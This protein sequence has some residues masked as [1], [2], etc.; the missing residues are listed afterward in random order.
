MREPQGVHLI[1]DNLGW[2]E[3][4]PVNVEELV[5]RAGGDQAGVFTVTR[6]DVEMLLR[7]VQPAAAQAVD[8]R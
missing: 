4:K 6:E 1:A 7:G 8:S 2:F 5:R 3:D